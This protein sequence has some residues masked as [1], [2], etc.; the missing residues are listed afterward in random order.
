MS[1]LKKLPIYD[2]RII[3][4]APEFAVYRGAESVNAQSFNAISQNSSQVNFNVV[5]P[6]PN[7]FIDRAIDWVADCFLSFN[8]L[9]NNGTAGITGGNALTTPIVTMGK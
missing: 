5:A 7:I 2:D 3:Q 8:V 4:N 1:E 9:V 6:S